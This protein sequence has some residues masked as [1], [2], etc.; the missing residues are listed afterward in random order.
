MRSL[1]VRLLAIIVGLGVVLAISIFALHHF[2][3]RRHANFYYKTA[4]RT[5][6]SDDPNQRLDAVKNLRRY[7]SLSPEDNDVR[8]ELGELIVDIA[9][10]NGPKYRSYY[11]DAFA[12]FEKVLRE[13]YTR[14]DVRRNLVE[15]AMDT[16]RYNDA[17][18]HLEVLLQ[19]SPNDVDLLTWLGRCQAWAEKDDLAKESF[20]KALEGDPKQIEPYTQIA[21]IL[22]KNVRLRGDRDLNPTVKA[23]ADNAGASA[24]PQSPADDKTDGKKTDDKKTDDKKTDDKKTDDKKDEQAGNNAEEK[25][26]EKEDEN[27]PDTWMNRLVKANPESPQA[28]LLRGQYLLRT[29]KS[30]EA[31]KEA[32][33]A[34][35]RM[36]VALREVGTALGKTAA[37]LKEL[38]GLAPTTPESAKT[39]LAELDSAEKQMENAAKS[40]ASLAEIEESPG[41]QAAI[42]EA[43]KNAPKALKAAGAALVAISE[44]NDEDDGIDEAGKAVAAA[45][46]KAFDELDVLNGSM[47]DSLLLLAEC[48]ANK[49]ESE[50]S[51][52]LATRAYTF[53]P[54]SAQV[55]LLLSRLEDHEGNQQKVRDW[56]E[57]GL[58]ATDESPILLWVK[59]NYLIDDLGSAAKHS[60][61]E[62][63]D[64]REQLREIS[65]KLRASPTRYQLPAYIGYLSA[66]AAFEQGQWAKASKEFETIRSDLSRMDPRLAVKSDQMV[67]KCYDRLGRSELARE[68]QHRA[69]RAPSPTANRFGEIA[70]MLSQGKVDEAIAAFEKLN[71]DGNLPEDAWV[72]LV[73]NNLGI[74]RLREKSKQDW[75]TFNRVL[76]EA[77]K[78]SPEDARLPLIAADALVAQEKIAE[79]QKLLS[80]AC[81][82]NP[83]DPQLWKSLIRLAQQKEDWKEADRLLADARKE[84]GDS[85]DL[86]ISEAV[87]I[88]ERYKKDS[89]PALTK[90]AGNTDQFS[91]EDKVRLLS[92]LAACSR[93]AGDLKLAH[94]LCR[95]AADAD[96]TNLKL[97]VFLFEIAAQQQDDAAMAKA[98]EEIHEIEEEGPL[99]HF[100]EAVRLATKFDK[101][102]DKDTNHLDEA[103][104]HLA[105]AKILRP[106]WDR[107]PSLRGRIELS[108]GNKKEATESLS[109][110]VE[111]GSRDPQAI[112]A[113]VHLLYEQGRNDEAQ[114][115]IGLLEDQDAQVSTQARRMQA[116]D[117][118]VRGDQEQ[119]LDNYRKI[120][121]NSEDFRDHLRLGQ[122]L[123]IF[124]QRAQLSKKDLQAKELFDEAEKS[125]RKAAELAPD[126][127]T[128]WLALVQFL[129]RNGKESAA[130]EVI[131]EA[132]KTVD[133]KYL[134]LALAR[135]F[136]SPGRYAEAQQQYQTAVENSDGK[137]SA[138][139]LFAAFYLQ[140]KKYEEAEKLLKKMIDGEQPASEADV[141]WARR[142][143]ALLLF[144]QG[145]LAKRRDAIAMVDKN[146]AK[147][148]S[149]LD[150]IRE[151]ARLLASF[152][153]PAELQ[154]A[155][156]LIEKLLSQPN[157]KPDD[158]FLMAGV[159]LAQKDWP[160]VTRHM[161]QLLAGKNIKPLWLRFYIEALLNRNEV[162]SAESYLKSLEQLEP[163]SFAVADFTVR[164]LSSRGQYD[165][166]L[167]V[168]D[169]YVNNPSAAGLD[170]M[171][172][173]EQEKQ[174]TARLVNAA[175]TLES[176]IEKLPHEEKGSDPQQLAGAKKFIDRTEAYWREIAKRH[177]EGPFRL[178]RFLS[179]HG[180]R[181]EA[182]NIVETAWQKGKP[183]SIAT[184]VVSLIFKGH[185]T[186][187]Q[188]K[189]V[190]RIINDAII[191]FGE[192]SP[193]LLAMAELRSIQRRY[194]EAESIYR[195]VLG[196][197]P[198]NV[199]ALN[200]LAVFLA[201]RNIK[202][203]ESLEFI[204]KAIEIA[205][206]KPTLR[207]SRASVHI[208]RG[209]WESALADIDA[210]IGGNPTAT[211]FFHK[212]QVLNGLKK[213]GE[214]IAALKAAQDMG[215][216]EDTLQ[217]LERP[218]YRQLRDNLK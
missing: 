159:M 16:N 79:A 199:V 213:K 26:V 85:A 188:V 152:G 136:Q 102:K 18:E 101:D 57:L 2:Q 214:A 62:Q 212:A 122:I 119:G 163:N 100:Y 6:D 36:P 29:Y 81:K 20:Q 139:Q 33:E 15:V 67:A 178:V 31:E 55:Y 151:K 173:K 25:L 90:L 111:L 131:A 135:C 165:K 149:S 99:W 194:E 164:I 186:P 7:V 8:A 95:K 52:K 208:S 138:A 107:V 4:Q 22:Q 118:L 218:A 11:G 73:Q 106:N 177:P 189:R 209:D 40:A 127:T 74:N 109:E 110:A 41:D 53:F 68:A 65:D 3:V 124:G 200:N 17:K 116:Q 5:K 93:Q 104:R 108:K 166:A 123:G 141:A 160:G 206:P 59:A 180:K 64:I 148:P 27:H 28:H 181:D 63:N 156:K 126:E 185:A 216:N 78:A 71:E 172:E 83:E 58:D 202:A 191:T 184:T 112:G 80:E 56:V 175:K 215:L 82:K 170:G 77:E 48:K 44:E 43:L 87:L 76:Q 97:C 98:V 45:K 49:A 192:T 9:K 153:N 105:Q 19:D 35:R 34:L 24:D 157:P 198:R 144:G 46:S 201:L 120:A 196:K 179:D 137:D 23:P 14:S 193:L 51:L 210:A 162:S 147:D 174:K 54:D 154:E 158:L 195:K 60:K 89:G 70:R 114:R 94:E 143:M 182:L 88:I 69:A 12:I 197:E 169:K 183:S 42:V 171:S 205:G 21:S 72:L 168:L 13:D 50:N 130:L 92:V 155:N 37:A 38:A 10:R 133:K 84:L 61:E 1:N 30:E 103:L 150:D 91:N 204:N 142:S 140:N 203:E 129:S 145:G 132:R 32:A 75:D 211:R 125:L 134:P 167:E 86:R 117:M 113:L 121:E 66:R 96:P 39:A 176:L 207:D 161:S 217:P 187:A 146:L 190:E 47:L 115:M 128:V